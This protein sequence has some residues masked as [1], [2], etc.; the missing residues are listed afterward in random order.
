MGE[1]L[2]AGRRR[3]VPQVAQLR[4]AQ[5][6]G[7]WV[8]FYPDKLYT[9]TLDSDGGLNITSSPLKGIYREALKREPA[10]W[11]PVTPGAIAKSG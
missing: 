7:V 6:E 3:G 10:L 5:G 8:P 1:L 2:E 4:V 9:V 11:E